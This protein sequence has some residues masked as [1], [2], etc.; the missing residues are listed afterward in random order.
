MATNLL[1]FISRH[2]PVETD[3]EIHDGDM[4]VVLR[5]GDTEVGRRRLNKGTCCHSSSPCIGTVFVQEQFR[6][7]FGLPAFIHISICYDEILA[8]AEANDRN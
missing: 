6:R 7:Q 8:A 2:L 1:R 3:V 4:F 5:C